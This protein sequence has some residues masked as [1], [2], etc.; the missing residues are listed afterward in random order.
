MN[1]APLPS[2][3]T[4][5]LSRT[6]LLFLPPRLRDSVKSSGPSSTPWLRGEVETL[7]MKYPDSSVDC[8]DNG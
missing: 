8:A 1:C 6:D 3:S 5:D 2:A 7:V 4:T